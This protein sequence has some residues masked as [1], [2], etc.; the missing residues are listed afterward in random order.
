MVFEQA[1]VFI[2]HT[3]RC[4]T[5]PWFARLA[6]KRLRRCMAELLPIRRKTL[7]N[8]SIDQSIKRDDLSLFWQAK[9]TESPSPKYLT[10]SYRI[11]R[12]CPAILKVQN[13]VHSGLFFSSFYI[14]KLVRLVSKSPRTYGCILKKY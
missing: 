9:H 5:G 1:E 4:Y 7:S 10:V 11:T 3:R 6:Q 12:Q 14:W 8:Q 2:C 13:K